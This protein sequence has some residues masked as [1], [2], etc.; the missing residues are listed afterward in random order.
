M[1]I[2][3]NEIKLHINETKFYKNENEF[4]NKFYIAFVGTQV[5]IC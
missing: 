3:Q 1:S 4:H 2:L 5:F